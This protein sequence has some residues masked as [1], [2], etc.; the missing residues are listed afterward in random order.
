VDKKIVC[1]IAGVSPLMMNRFTDEA[2]GVATNRERKNRE[3]RLPPK[4]DAE[5]RLYKNEAG[6]IIMPQANIMATIRDGGL[7]FKTGKK[8]ITTQKSSLVPAALTF[9]EVY[10]PFESKNGWTVDQRPV[11]IPATGN[12]ILRFRPMFHDWSIKFEMDLDE[13]VFSVEMLRELVD[14][15]GSKAGLCDFRPNRRGPF[16]KFKVNKW[17]VKS[18]V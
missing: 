15:A 6:A 8:Q 10:Y 5:E 4:E 3:R 1:V 7:F 17:D 2:A 9:S 14:A 11:T 16:G 18:L 13:T 12:K